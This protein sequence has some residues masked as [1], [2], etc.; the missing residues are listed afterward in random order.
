MSPP[1][2]GRTATPPT[3][4]HVAARIRSAYHRDAEV[5]YPPVD[6]SDLRLGD[7]A[8]GYYLM[9]NAFAPYKRVDI[10]VEAFNRLGREL[11]DHRHRP[12]RG[13]PA[14]ARRAERA[15]SRVDLA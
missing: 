15:L 13:A 6:L 7:G 9:V 11:L 3:R 1:P 5:I 4:R 14:S 12:G 8:G 2:T 10:A